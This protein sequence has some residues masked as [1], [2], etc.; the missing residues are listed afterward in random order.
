MMKSIKTLCLAILAV[1]FFASCGKQHQAKNM[2][3]DFL[4]THLV[5]NSRTNTHF[6]KLD[7]TRMISPEAVMA[8]R[9]HMKT[10]KLFKSD[11]TYSSDD[12]PRTLYYIRVSYDKKQ[13]DGKVES[14]KQTFYFDKDIKHI[15]AYKE[16]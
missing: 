15:I 1:V 5:D 12:V 3:E 10:V 2:V 14:Y 7:S 11:V 13:T 8:L 9:E 16:G 6:S 4:D